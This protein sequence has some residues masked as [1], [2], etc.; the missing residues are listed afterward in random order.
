MS[1]ADP[2]ASAPAGL[3]LGADPSRPSEPLLRVRDLRVYFAGG[4]VLRRGQTGR[5]PLVRAVDGVS[6]E[7]ARG[8][9]LGVVGESGCGKSTLGRAILALVP[10]TSGEVRFDGRDVLAMRR[11]ELRALRCRAQMVFQDPAGSL[12]PLMTIESAV[13]EPLLVQRLT[14]TRADRAARVAAVLRRVGLDADA[15]PR[16]PHEFSGGQRQR[17]VIARALVLEPELLV[18]DEPVSALDVSIQAQI[19]NLLV[20]LQVAGK[21]AYVFV[22]HNLAVVQH[23]SD[24]VAVMY[25]GRIVETAPTAVLFRSP[26]HP[27]THALL[28][29]APEPDPA[30]RPAL[31]LLRGEPP[32][33]LNPPAGCAF[34]PRCPRA[35]ERCR[36]DTP[37]LSPA[38]N[39][40]P[41]HA[42]ACF[43]P[44]SP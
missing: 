7:V 8:A 35:Q 15:M 4:D 43:F 38:S 5:G 27:Y 13:G 26:Q 40:T 12:N 16:Y 14:R 37:E 32:S 41:A 44:G 17:I 29:A 3:P 31:A 22:S 30:A 6:L 19:L 9:T 23:I 36:R 28:A 24:R 20:E 39:T 1:R 10:A 18:C 21:L 11:R 42:V 34:H 33:P 25:L 2:P